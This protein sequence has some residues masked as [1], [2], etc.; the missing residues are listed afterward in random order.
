M[1]RTWPFLVVGLLLAAFTGV[2]LYGLAGAARAEPAAEAA[3]TAAVVVAKADIPARTVLTSEQLATK[4]YPVDL[5]PSG[6]ITTLADAVGQTTSVPITMGAPVVRAQLSA[7]GA[8]QASALEI[9]P[10]K[11]LV[12]FPTA[13]P[14]TGASLVSVGDRVDLLATVLSGT[15]ENARLTQTTVQ[16]LEV[17][18]VLGPTKDQPQRA[19]A[20]VFM[21][22]HQVA[23]VLKYLRDAQSTVDVAVRSHDEVDRV[24]TSTVDLQYLMATYGI[25]R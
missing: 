22:D 11:V 14:L 19:R 1:T 15:G 20:L 16:G 17:I 9:E 5:V 2:A 7:V 4:S 6:T 24:T 10:G 8:R 25:K 3:Q 21:V 23:L 18:E 12:A 13:D